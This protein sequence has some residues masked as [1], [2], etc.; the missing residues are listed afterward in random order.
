MLRFK[1]RK[2]F[3]PIVIIVQFVLYYTSIDAKRKTIE[4]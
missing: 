3:K 1:K 2:M 4:R